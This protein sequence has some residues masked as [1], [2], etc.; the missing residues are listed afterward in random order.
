MTVVL[1]FIPFLFY[2]FAA[3][4]DSFTEKMLSVKDLE[5]AYF[6]VDLRK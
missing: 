3:L 4:H 6:S 2:Y 5:G 1:H